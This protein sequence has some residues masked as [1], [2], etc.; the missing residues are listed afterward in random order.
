MGNIVKEKLKAGQVTLGGWMMLG[1]PGIGQ[2]FASCGFDWVAVDMEHTAF[3]DET[4]ENIIRAIEV[5]GAV[6]LARMQG[7]DPV[8]IKRALDAGARGIIVPMVNSAAEARQMVSYAKFPPEGIR[9][10]S[11]SRATNYGENF[12]DY[13]RNH[14]SDVVLVAMIEHIDGV[15]RIEE[16]VR[17][18][19]LDALFFGPYDLSSS[20]GIVGQFDHPEF[21]QAVEKVRLAAGRVKLPIGI[22]VVAP[23]PDQIRK[24]AD[25]GFQFIGC[26]VDTQILYHLGKQMAGALDKSL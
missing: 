11:F 23:D 2:I 1:H 5:K 3:S 14:N 8:A 9:G 15:N 13:Y 20:M 10:A 18:E 19:G 22:H 7:N 25:E 6:A 21:K 12:S 4:L 26:G 16:I 17:V 24:R